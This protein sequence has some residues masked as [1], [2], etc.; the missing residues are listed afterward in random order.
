MDYAP[1]MHIREATRADI[2]EIVLVSRQSFIDAF[3]HLYK[4]ADLNAFLDEWRTPERIGANVADPDT[5]LAVADE[6]GS[7]VGYCTT[8]FGKGFDERPEPRPMKPAYLG[9]LYCLQT[10]T[11]RGVGA[12]L[13]EDCIAQARRRGCD[14]V[15]L[16]VYSENFGGQRFYRR[17]GFAH[18]ADIDFWVGNQRDD[19]FLY[20]LKL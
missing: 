20:E 10:A 3:G 18:V 4:P 14:A 2:A 12:A 1:V 19:E 9:Q 5:R 13:I 16:S 7:I 17:H 6:D 11:G 15:Q 8:T